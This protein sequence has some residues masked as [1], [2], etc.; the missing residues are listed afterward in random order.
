MAFYFLSSSD[1]G[2]I[3]FSTPFY[4]CVCMRE[5]IFA[6]CFTLCLIIN[7]L[8][9]LFLTTCL[10]LSFETE[11]LGLI[12]CSKSCLMFDISS[13][14]TWYQSETLC[15][16]ITVRTRLYGDAQ[17]SGCNNWTTLKFEWWKF[18]V[19]LIL[20]FPLKL[21]LRAYGNYML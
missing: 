5:K 7:S 15:C 18:T 13:F 20:L 9:L 12:P 19:S 4:V 10:K 8:H 16:V 2:N 14:D 11:I 1:A 21:V 17:G 3:T 6:F